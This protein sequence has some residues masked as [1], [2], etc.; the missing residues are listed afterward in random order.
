MSSAKPTNT[1]SGFTQHGPAVLRIRRASGRIRTLDASLVSIDGPWVTCTGSWRG[2]R[3]EYTLVFNS[4]QVL[5]IRY[6]EE[7]RR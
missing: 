3:R 2:E 6:L 1:A 5:E 4:R 7:S